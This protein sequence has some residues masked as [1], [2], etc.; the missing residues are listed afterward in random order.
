MSATLFEE[1]V[2]AKPYFDRN[3]LLV[4]REGDH[5]VGFVHAAFGPAEDHQQ[6]A[7]DPG[8]ILMLLVRPHEAEREIAAALIAAAENY[9]RTAGTKHFVAGG[10]PPLDAFYTGLYGGTEL[11]GVLASDERATTFLSEAGYAPN[12]KT[13]I[14]QRT[15]VGFRAP[16]DRQQMLL[17]R[18]T[19]IE[20]SL[21][22]RARDWWDAWTK[23]TCERSQHTLLSKAGGETLASIMT[24]A[25]EPL[26]STWGVHAAGIFGL[27]AN[28][29][30]DG[31]SH[32]RFLL[33]EVLRHM[34]GEGCTLA[35]INVAE[36]DATLA[37]T[38]AELD[39]Q[40][41]DQGIVMSKS[42]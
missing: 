16:I 32:A 20:V 6:L 10:S 8:V 21:C 23:V 25:V 42:A 1:H 30:P 22:P 4:A 9:L 7:L 38:I 2:V 33:C 15:L 34:E 27:E 24:W 39:F 35:E 19:T 17:R 26:A 28:H 41:I 36:G 14:Y 29:S 13:E 3:G 37:K 11:S 5:V 31:Q 12:S 40:A 18:N